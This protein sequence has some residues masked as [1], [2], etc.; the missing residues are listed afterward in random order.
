MTGEQYVLCFEKEGGKKEGAN[1]EGEGGESYVLEFQ[2]EGSG[3][4]GQ[5]RMGGEGDGESYVL[6]FRTEGENEGDGGK[7]K[8]E[9][10][11]F[12]LL[13]EWGGEREGERPAG[14]EGGEGESFVLHFQTEAQNEE[15]NT[16]NAGYPEGPNNNLE[17]SCQPNQALVPL[18][19][20]EV[21]FELGDEA[22]MEAQGSGES[23]QMIALIEGQGGG[24]GEAGSYSEAGGAV[25]ESGG[26]MEGIFQLEGGEGIVIIEVSTSSLR[27]G[28]MNRG[29]EGR[30]TE[31]SEVKG[32]N[33]KE[34]NSAENTEGETGMN[35]EEITT[36]NGPATIS[37]ETEFSIDS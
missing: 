18:G 19:R 12:N 27:E 6:R 37:H 25:G 32:E 23:V 13:K 22:K 15:G 31:R 28:G 9:V 14:E 8:G 21:V 4:G 35:E 24:V 7:D 36:T 2:G 5:V 1:I 20:Q 34:W 3:E 29:G 30:S 16:S 33:E 11:S 26:A 17:L 10:M